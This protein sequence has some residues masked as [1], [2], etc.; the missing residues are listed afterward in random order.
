MK[1]TTITLP[2]EL[3]EFVSREAHRRQTSVSAL[4]RDLIA[5][6]LA[7]DSPREIPWAGL[8]EDPEMVPAARIDDELGQHWADDID[9]DRR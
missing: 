7:L 8:F 9:R 4:V 3:A 5:R 2:D 1:R 6:G